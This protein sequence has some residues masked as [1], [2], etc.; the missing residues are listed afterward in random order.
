MELAP[1]ETPFDETLFESL[2]RQGYACIPHFLPESLRQ[3]LYEEALAH[4]RRHAMRQ[5]HIGQGR[6]RHID[7]D[8]RGDHI[9]WLDGGASTQR[10]FLALMERYRIALNRHLYLGINRYEAHF[11]VY[12]PGKRY[13]LHWDNF[14]GRGNRLVTTVLYLNPEWKAEWGG[15]L[16]LYAPDE[17]TL[18]E[19]IVPAPGL[20]AT[21]ISSE[22]PHE[23]MPTRR[24]RV[25]IAGWLRRDDPF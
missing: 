16:R 6:A 15:Q 21:F 23:V 22:I 24:P 14:R 9:R 1:N 3:P 5:A 11:A 18:I 25:S 19:E 8:I 4:F 7:S 2:Q 12:P 20:L 13:R 17:T 10:R